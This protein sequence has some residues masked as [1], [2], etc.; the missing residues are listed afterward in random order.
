[1]TNQLRDHILTLPDLL[2][3]LLDGYA[4][5]VRATLPASLCNEVRSVYLAGCGDSHHAAI[6]AELAFQQLA[7]LP[8]RALPSMHFGRYTAGWLGPAAPG[9]NLVLAISVSGQ[10][11]RTVEALDLARQVGAIAVAVTGNPAG[12]LAEVAGHVLDTPVPPLPGDGSAVIPGLRTFAASLAA[13]YLVAIH[14]GE[15]RG[16]LSPAE[17]TALRS[18]LAGLAEGAAATIATCDA[19]AARLAAEWQ[20]ASHFVFCGSGPSHAAALFSAAKIVEASGDV[21]LGQDLEEWAHLQYF[22]RESDSPTFLISGGGWDVDRALEVATA[23]RAIGRR[24]AIVAPADSPL[25]AAERDA[26]LPLWS[27]LRECFSPLLSSLP[28]A[29]LA[30]Q[31]AAFLGE[32]YFRAFSGG[33]SIEGGGGISRIR[34]SQRAHLPYR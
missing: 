16:H 20:D 6:A 32:P 31:R 34:T 9:E 11:S 4:T 21:A 3:T 5:A 17:A 25:A 12:P 19:A 8:C 7:G 26:W 15:V 22:G 10:V 1:M 29:L 23:A 28:G 2:A 27:P 18:E 30:A 14:L 33:R 13:L 24:L